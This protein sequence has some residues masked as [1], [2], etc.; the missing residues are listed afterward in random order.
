MDLIQHQYK[1]LITV[2]PSVDENDEKEKF[3][4]YYRTVEKS[5]SGILINNGWTQKQ[6][7]FPYAK[8][9]FVNIGLGPAVNVQLFWY[10]LDSV[11]GI[12]ELEEIKDNNI[13]GFYD[14]VKYSNFTFTENGKVK[15][16]PW[17]IYTEFELGVS[18]ET[19]RLNLLFSFENNV[20][21]FY[22]IIEIRYENLMGEKFKKLLYLS[23]DN[24]AV[25]LPVS[26]EYMA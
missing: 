25:M 8:L 13:E 7:Y 10:Q 18:E 23:F 21:A 15:N 17:P 22:S 11:K 1:P 26:K 9:S 20:M 14:K 2:S 3:R 5:D 12:L 4:T 6:T 16:E 19:N 24:G